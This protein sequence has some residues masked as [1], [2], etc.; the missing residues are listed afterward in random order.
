MLLHFLKLTYELLKLVDFI[1][2]VSFAG[3][4]FLQRGGTLGTNGVQRNGG[5]VD[6]RIFYRD[7]LAFSQ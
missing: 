2:W 6:R 5:R 7:G 4:D 3:L 1:F